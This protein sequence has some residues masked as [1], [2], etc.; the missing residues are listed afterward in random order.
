MSAL[1]NYR[2][3]VDL[4]KKG[5]T[6]EAQEKIM[7]LRESALALQEENLSLR[8][9]VIDLEESLRSRRGLQ[10][11]GGLY[12]RLQE[13]GGREGPFC[14]KCLDV[15]DRLVRLYRDTLNGHACWMCRGCR[16][17]YR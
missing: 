1:P 6:I 3:I 15:T 12:W 9:K 16:E 7:E 2:D 17:V 8:Q 14:Q 11:D 13:T 10:W 5:A 4:L